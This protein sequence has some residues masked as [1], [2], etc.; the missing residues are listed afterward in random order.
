MPPK[1]DRPPPPVLALSP[2]I[3]DV[4][5]ALRLWSVFSKVSRDLQNGARLENM[6][7]RLACKSRTLHSETQW[8]PTPESLTSDD[9]GGVFQLTPRP[10]PTVGQFLFD[11]IPPGLTD[12]LTAPRKPGYPTPSSSSC[13]SSTVSIAV[14]A[15][16]DQ[17]D[18]LVVPRVV[19]LTPTPNLSPH[20]TPPATPQLNSTSPK[21]SPSPAALL[22]PPVP[23]SVAQEPP[24]G[25]LH[26]KDV[27][28]PLQ[29]MARSATRGM[30]SPVY[31]PPSASHPSSAY[32]PNSTHNLPLGGGVKPLASKPPPHATP[33]GTS[34]F[35]LPPP[36]GSS[37]HSSSQSSGSS[38]SSRERHLREEET[39]KKDR[40]AY[41]GDARGRDRTSR[42]EDDSEK[43][44]TQ[45]QCLEHTKS[46]PPALLQAATQTTTPQP[47]QPQLTKAPLKP[48]VKPSPRSVSAPILAMEP[49]SRPPAPSDMDDTRS[50][51]SHAT[52]SSNA[53]VR[54]PRARQPRS[55]SS[56]HRQ[57]QSRS[58]SRIRKAGT[59]RRNVVLNDLGLPNPAVNLRAGEALVVNGKRRTTVVLATSDEDSD[60][61][62]EDDDVSREEGTVE[63]EDN[64][65]DEEEGEDDEEWEDESEE[66][67]QEAESAPRIPANAR[68]PPPSLQQQQPVS[69]RPG[70]SRGHSTGNGATTTSTELR[71]L[72][73]RPTHRS[74]GHLPSLVKPLGKHNRSVSSAAL[75]SAALEAQRQRD[76]FAKAPRV[77]YENLTTLASTRPGGLTLLLGGHQPAQPTQQIPHRQR[78]VGGFGG[79]G[80]AMTGARPN[81]GGGTILSPI[82]PTPAPALEPTGPNSTKPARQQQQQPKQ[83]P[84]AAPP[85]RRPTLP[86]ALS[87]SAL[88][89]H[90]GGSASG[91]LGKSTAARPVVVTPQE[92]AFSP[93]AL[94]AAQAKAQTQTAT[95][96]G[97]GSAGAGRGGYR[98]RGP[99][100]EAEFDDDEESDAD[101]H[102]RSKSKDDASDDG[103]QVS[104]SVAHEKLRVLAERSDIHSRAKNG[105]D[106]N[107]A[108]RRRLYEQA[109]VPEWATPAPS[110]NGDANDQ[111]PSGRLQQQQPSRS[112]SAAPIGFPYY[113]PH[114]EPPSSPRTTRQ[115]MLRNEMSESLRHNLLW[116]RKQARTELSGPAPR[117]TKSTVNVPLA[118]ERS[119]VRLTPR[120]PGTERTTPPFEQHGPNFNDS[121]PGQKRK[122]VRTLSYDTYDDFHRTGW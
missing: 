49:I 54:N 98:P 47:K 67:P 95:R 120:A 45:T 99:P 31:S 117:R 40:Q 61:S 17:M 71:H 96:S 41:A 38:E 116:H 50:V 56:A 43:P 58:R 105:G 85:P 24:A 62:D 113:L 65:D 72:P 34:K 3:H 1:G 84:T 97:N 112:S 30:G 75:E 122:L 82:P 57:A 86:R 119:L 25:T 70:H 110:K 92:S 79:L 104:K 9:P 108:E 107:S 94:A 121:G 73:T 2:R 83:P 109:G 12:E 60:W 42:V 103:L 29:L 53:K 76:L 8:P 32:A 115:Q 80:L 7:W 27:P 36:S 20:P 100:A 23:V 68:A 59:S 10:K 48:P 52:S 13:A 77:S 118:T 90:F 89:P 74:A 81:G 66:P 26:R 18:P 64:K 14:Q 15:P 22:P 93:A 69:R 87:S 114:P 21:R 46:E 88:P 102:G 78:P 19:I 16:H 5:D 101:G 44:K 6:A 55:S 51:S 111:P 91:S 33:R 4:D 35:F 28:G 37:W 63:T 39:R 106:V 11:K